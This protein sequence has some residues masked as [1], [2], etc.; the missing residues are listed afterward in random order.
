MC[1]FFAVI[2]PAQKAS[3]NFSNRRTLHHWGDMCVYVCACV[4]NIVATRGRN[5]LRAQNILQCIHNVCVC[6]CMCVCNI[7]ATPCP[8][9]HARMQWK[10]TRYL[11]TNSIVRLVV[12]L[13]LC[14]S[15]CM[16]VCMYACMYVCK[17][18]SNVPYIFRLNKS[19]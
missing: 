13:L 9:K 19:S 5:S 4:C 3:T 14:P 12:H 17:R 7:V 11:R 10:H 16:H 18:N 15:I 8:T 2:W 6:V 1:I